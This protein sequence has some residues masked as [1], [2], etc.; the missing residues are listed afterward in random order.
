M[1]LTLAVADCMHLLVTYFQARRGG[2]DKQA[3]VIHT[4]R[5]NF[6][7]VMLTS[8]TTVIGFLALNFSES[9][10]FHDLGNVSAIGVTAAW[11][12]AIS[13]LPALITF[14]PGAVA[15]DPQAGNHRMAQLAGWVRIH[16]L[17]GVDINY[18]GTWESGTVEWLISLY[19]RHTHARDQAS[20]HACTLPHNDAKNAHRAWVR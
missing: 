5:L 16:A 19:V 7:A 1:I 20:K 2:A 6:Q 4:V 18:E 12:F 14:M 11:F 17:D 8:I 10:P 3:A 13:L 15:T 9:P